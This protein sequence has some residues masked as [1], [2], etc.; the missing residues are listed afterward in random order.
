MREEQ[1]D[2]IYDAIMELGRIECDCH[3][4]VVPS[5]SISR[6]DVAIWLDKRHI[7]AL[8]DI[9]QKLY[10][11]DGHAGNIYKKA[12]AQTLRFYEGKAEEGQEFA[13]PYMPDKDAQLIELARR[14][15]EAGQK[16]KETIFMLGSKQLREVKEQ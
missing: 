8:Q 16:L 12:P 13:E 6:A 10:T 14:E 15:S 3:R 7:E 1:I 5:R 9:A 11:E 4:V 2:L